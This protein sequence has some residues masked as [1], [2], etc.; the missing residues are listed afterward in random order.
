[1]KKIFTLILFSLF[2]FSFAQNVSPEYV[3]GQIYLKFR[4]GT[5]KNI[6]KEDPNNIPLLKIPI[7]AELIGKYGIT[8]ASKPF[9]QAD[10]D[11]RL[12]HILQLDF[13]D[14]T[15]INDLIADLASNRIVEYAEKVMLLKTHITP[16]DFTVA[17]NTS[18]TYLNWIGAPNAWTVY[19]STSNGT[20]NI[21]VAIVDNAIQRTHVDLAANIWTNPGEI[22]ANSIDDDMN[23]YV[24]DVNGWDPA[25]G[26]NNTNP[27]NYAMDHGTHTSGCAAAVNNNGIGA[28]SIGW[29]L[30][31]IPVK[32]AKNGD[33][34]TSVGYGYQGII[35]AA[36]CKA[37]V[38]SCSW[39][40][41]GAPSTSAQSI[42][43]YAWNKGCI[44]ICSA[45]ND[46]D[47]VLHYPAAYNNVYAVAAT[48]N[49]N[50][51]KA[52]F[53]CYG[54]WVDISSPGVNIYS[55]LPNASN[56]AY[57]Q[58]SGTSM[59]CPITAGL[60]GLMLAKYPY[61]TQN[62]VLNCISST[63]V[64]VNAANSASLAGQLGAGRI[65]A[66]AAMQCAA[67]YTGT[68]PVANFY[69]LTRNTCPNTLVPF[70]DSSGYGPTSWAWSFQSGTPATSTSSNP[71]V[72]WTLPGVYN[73][74]LT[75]TNANG[76]NTKVKTAYVTV[77]PPINLPLV[78]GFQSS[79]PFLP[80]NWTSYNVGN[81]SVYWK[82]K[83]GVGG[84]VVNASAK[85]ALFNDY[86]EDA[87]GDRDEMKT[88]RYNFSNVANA[89]IRFDVAYKQY[90]V[91]A[92]INP[93][94]PYSDTL[95][96]RLSTN[97]GLSSTQIYCKG[98]QSLTTSPGTLQANI[99]V[100]TATEW[101]TDSVSIT[102]QA[103]F[104][105]NVMAHFI[106]RGH[107]G[108]AM[109]VD[110]INIFLP[111]PTMAVASPSL[112]CTNTAYTF[113]NTTT[114][115]AGY[116]WTSNP[117]SSISAP[118]GTNTNI[119]FTSPGVY[120]ITCT[121]N[122]GTVTNFVVKTITVSI[123][124]T[125]AIANSTNNVCS[126]TNVTLTASGASTYSW[127]TA[128]T[129]SVI[130]VTPSANTTYTV[131]GNNNNCYMVQS[132]ALNA[133]VTPTVTAASQTICASGTATIT[134]GGATTYSWSTGFVGNPLM[135]SPSANT[136]VTV[137]GN[138]GVCANSKTVGITI[139]SSITIIPSATTPTICAGGTVGLSATGA[140]TYTWNP[141]NLLG[142][143]Q[144]VTPATSQIYTVSGTNSGCNG[145]ATISI[146]I[147]GAPALVLT[148]NT[149]SMCAGGSS[150]INATGYTTYT[151]NPGNL[152]GPSQVLSPAANQIYTVQG[153]LGNCNGTSTAVITVTNFPVVT[154]TGGTFVCVGKNITL[155]ANGAMSY[156]WTAGPMTN[157]NT[158]SPPSNATFVVTG[159]NSNCT[160][161]AAISVS[162]N[163]NPTLA[164]S[165][166]S[167]PICI[168]DAV[169]ITA[170]G[171]NTYTWNG[172][173]Q[174]NPIFVTPTITTQ[175]TVT[176]A[177]NG[178]TST[179]V[180]EMTV[181]ACPNG[182][183]TQKLSNNEL[184]IFPNP[185]TDMIT[186]SYNGK[187]F[188]YTMY[189]NVG[190]LICSE[191]NVMN[192]AKIK[193]NEYAKGVYYI[194]VVSDGEKTRR[195][196]IKD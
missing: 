187:K 47:A 155:T 100:P 112:G 92:N 133:T 126:G 111:A 38:I 118:N 24:D 184:L 167:N 139:G 192:N 102:S 151:W 113:T 162:V 56:N 8:K 31:I 161:T 131:Q 135:I 46:N 132:I 88:P 148:P 165:S 176:G 14:A 2:T 73:V 35:Y 3:D 27:T 36:K 159:A 9:Y 19:N 5:I 185:S 26:D 191:K 75:V 110:N 143:N 80:T 30:K 76:S 190:R 82:L 13:S 103:A 166:S 55:T 196:L 117:P 160:S 95:E 6:S 106:N 108:Q 168:G 115:A 22:P 7:L 174:F 53:S 186:I 49:N 153:K 96:V 59:A 25:D 91:T 99:F 157:T 172:G 194:E 120:S 68:P 54:S 70:V 42:I 152:S 87:T 124:P 127:S 97:C 179:A 62:N 170:S 129:T 146:S 188:D 94:N 69:T 41:T 12:T 81:D 121:A 40:G 33:P 136:V 89:K 189:D 128:Q 144:T 72:M 28:S 85:C 51:V 58:Y 195:K 48:G 66:Y 15:K 16:N 37:R 137:F 169:N 61:M 142:A 183:Q 11:I 178:C 119:T 101:R 134:A 29:N 23:G 43:D 123:Q 147:I 145:N 44:I 104:Q 164:V 79:P 39:G 17:N 177:V 74:S 125:V 138:N 57:G 60:A 34:V 130:V 109:Y 175:Y 150:T 181:N 71:S 63:A 154:I 86:E 156:T 158:V 182:V 45:G 141:G 18:S 105:P 107:Y 114:G 171:A 32:C 93:Q 65:N 149:S 50:D 10:D 173:S 52:S 140:T 1:M 67:S 90:D 116:T 163:P 21:T 64:N 122:N 84:F 20:T 98:G 180:F 193:V 83:Q 4:T 77:G 78:E